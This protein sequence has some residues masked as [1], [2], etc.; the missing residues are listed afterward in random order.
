MP[1]KPKSAVARAD[2]APAAPDQGASALAVDARDDLSP[3]DVSLSPESD[4]PPSP[5]GA[6][7]PMVCIVS[8]LARIEQTLCLMERAL[9]AV[10]G[11]CSVN[12]ELTAANF[13]LRS[14]AVTPSASGAPGAAAAPGPSARVVSIIVTAT[15]VALVGNEH[16]FDMRNT[17]KASNVNAKWNSAPPARWVVSVAAWTEHKAAWE[18]TFGVS[19]VERPA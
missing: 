13:A 6:A 7:A 19:F 2:C 11:V 14:G 15:D 10:R 4:P 3:T 5:D 8:S 16:T 12:S 17:L 9:D 1:R 18:S